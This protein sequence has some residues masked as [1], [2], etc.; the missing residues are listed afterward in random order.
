ML[1]MYLAISSKML[2]DVI[3]IDWIDWMTLE[4]Y[5]DETRVDWIDFTGTRAQT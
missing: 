3:G 5:W 4:L 1:E 2:K